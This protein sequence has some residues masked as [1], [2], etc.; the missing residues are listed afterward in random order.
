MYSS[1]Y[2]VHPDAVYCSFVAHRFWHLT[3]AE[4][5]GSAGSGNWDTRIEINLRSLLGA[6]ITGLG[7]LEEDK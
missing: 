4:A 2:P 7:R 1:R 5:L 6:N 3:S